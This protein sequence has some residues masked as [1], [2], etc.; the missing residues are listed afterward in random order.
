MD[1]ETAVPLLDAVPGGYC[2]E[3]ILADMKPELYNY[4]ARKQKRMHMLTL[5]TILAPNP[6]AVGHIVDDQAVVV[7]PEHGEVKVFNEVGTH[8]WELVDGSRSIRDIAELVCEAFEVAPETAVQDT[9]E[10]VTEILKED[11]ICITPG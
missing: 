11:I 6:N 4:H 7:V 8:I 2:H 3:Q 10:F 5:D 9:L 1:G